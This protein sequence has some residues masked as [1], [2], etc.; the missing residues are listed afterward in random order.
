MCVLA[1]IVLLPLSTFAQEQIY[2]EK[3]FTNEYTLQKA[4]NVAL[5]NNPELAALALE[6]EAAE[7]RYKQAGL[8]D[9]PVFDAE[10]EN[11]SG[12]N[13][14]FSRTENTFWITQP[15]LLGGKRDRKKEITLKEKEMVL[16]NHEAKRSDVILAVE[17]VMYDILLYQ[18]KLEFAHEAQGIAQELYKFKTKKVNDGK[19]SS[20]ELLSMEIELSEAEIEILN[21]KK[22][23]KIAKKN[24]AQLWGSNEILLGE[25]KG[26]LERT[27]IIP[28]VS[29]LKKCLLERNPTIKINKLKE[30]QG[31][32]L[33]QYA[34]S[35][36]IPDVDFS[37]GVRQFNEDD[38]YTFVG[39]LSIPL[40]LFNRNQ[41]GIQEALVN[42]KRIKVDTYATK[43]NLFC[44]S[45][46]LQYPG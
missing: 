9:N 14:G 8:W 3:D 6:S 17:E 28:E 7:A 19:S 26:S 4:I 23:L 44:L 31:N 2:G 5:K 15:F 40:P 37:F 10:S 36:R 18:K 38:N 29:D 42:Q 25:A 35:E 33:L 27:F 39:A 22:D 34:K 43:N 12:N 21:V 20:D 16:L 1:G 32:Y 46:K 45:T 11:F 24:L 13:P 30:E 41:G